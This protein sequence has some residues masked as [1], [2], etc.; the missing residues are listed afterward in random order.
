VPPRSFTLQF[1]LLLCAALLALFFVPNTTQ[2]NDESLSS[3]FA[4]IDFGGASLLAISITSLMLAVELVG[5][6]YPW[7]HPMIIGLIVSTVAGGTL[8]ALFEKHY[9]AEPVFPLY[10]LG[11]RDIVS[12]YMVTLLQRAAQFSVRLFSHHSSS[13][14]RY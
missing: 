6:R 5:K 14:V 3:K 10:L 1:P 8:F 11:K 13:K 7:N 9:A 2:E 4:R 12:S